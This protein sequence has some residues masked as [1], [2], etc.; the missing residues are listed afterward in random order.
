MNASSW[1]DLPISMVSS[2]METKTYPTTFGEVLKGIRAG[3]WE[4][5]VKRVRDRY[6]S[7]RKAAVEEGK[8]DPSAEAKKA[9]NKLKLKMPAVTW[10]SLWNELT[11]QSLRT[12]D[13]SASMPIIARSRR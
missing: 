5:I 10:S 9:A 13:F 2:A 4:R 3:K 1:L 7:A 12:P 6:A 11:A 8:P